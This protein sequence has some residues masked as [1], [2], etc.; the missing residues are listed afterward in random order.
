M[1]GSAPYRSRTQSTPRAGR[2]VGRAPA[3]TVR[4]S[5]VVSW[6]AAGRTDRQIASALGLSPRTVHKHLEHVYRKLGVTHAT[7]AAAVAH[8]VAGDAL[9]LR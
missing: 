5:E 3:L 7:A 1:E 9:T 6:L 2:L 4:E 8:G